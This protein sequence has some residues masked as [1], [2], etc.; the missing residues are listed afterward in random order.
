VADTPMNADLTLLIQTYNRPERI[1]AF[2][3]ALQNEDLSGV[4]VIIVDNGSTTPLK[5]LAQEIDKLPQARLVRREKNCICVH[6]GQ[7]SIAL[8]T[9]A[10][11]L[12]PGDDDLIVPG[13]LQQL[14]QQ[15][16]KNPEIDVLITSMDVVN[17]NGDKTGQNYPPSKGQLENPELLLARLLKENIIAWPSTLFRKEMFS[18]LSDGNFTYRTSL[19]WA[20]WILNAQKIKIV[21]T[22]LRVIQYLRH[23]QNES[24]VVLSNQ[25][26]SE[27][28]SM[29]IRVL[30]NPSFRTYLS[31]LTKAQAEVLMNAISEESGLADNFE[32]NRLMITLLVQGFSIDNPRTWEPYLMGLGML[33]WNP[34]S[35]EITHHGEGSV[36]NY[37]LGYPYNLD[38]EQ[39]SCLGKFKESLFDSMGYTNLKKI[40]TIT[41][42]CTCATNQSNNLVLIDCKQLGLLD[43]EELTSLILQSASERFHNME[44]STISGIERTLVVCYRKLRNYVPRSVKM[45]IQK[46]IH[47]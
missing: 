19:D 16:N 31:S 11:I 40:Q 23:D 9:S 4:E 20:F 24:A 15:I 10:F 13:A 29:R 18:K 43:L 1:L 39:G 12:N 17:Q 28:I 14:R 33:P 3:R 7:S 42:T 36:K 8:A 44:G 38:F 27:S 41:F 6:C 34:K 46:V 35:F 37:W 5:Q 2:V 25:Q 22:N 32:V 30:S 26:L 21:S 47:R 45:Q